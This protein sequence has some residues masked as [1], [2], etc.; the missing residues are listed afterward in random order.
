LLWGVLGFYARCCVEL[1]HSFPLF[2]DLLVDERVQAVHRSPGVLFDYGV[3]ELFD[4]LGFA[5]K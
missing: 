4:E 1:Q 5:L 2:S 3:E